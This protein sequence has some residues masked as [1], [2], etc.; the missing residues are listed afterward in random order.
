MEFI[1]LVLCAIIYFN[2]KE[3]TESIEE[4]LEV[5]RGILEESDNEVS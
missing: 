2:L 5:I 3:N 1:I 4:Q